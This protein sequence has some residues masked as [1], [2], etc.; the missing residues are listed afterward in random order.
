MFNK[1]KDEKEKMREEEIKA[2]AEG[3]KKK[4]IKLIEECSNFAHEYYDICNMHCLI[5]EACWKH[6]DVLDKGA[7]DK[8]TKILQLG[9]EL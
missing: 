3:I 9:D 2:T 1:E 6:K 5:C 4:L 8:G 7:L